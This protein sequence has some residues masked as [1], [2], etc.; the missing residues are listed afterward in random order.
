VEPIAEF[1]LLQDAC[2]IVPCDREELC[3]HASLIFTT[4]LVHICDNSFVEDIHCIDM[5]KQE[6]HIISTLN[7]LG[8]LTS[9]FLII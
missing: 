9:M 3:G 8:Y 2:H 1:P 5:E 7:T 4:Q 6:L